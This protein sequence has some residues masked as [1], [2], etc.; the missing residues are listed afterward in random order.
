MFMQ[1][2][3]FK[4]HIER[5]YGSD[6]EYDIEIILPDGTSAESARKYVFETYVRHSM[7]DRD[8]AGLS[9]LENRRVAV[10]TSDEIG[11][12]K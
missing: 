1:K 12:F 5:Y 6:K 11:G 8:S 2:F 9:I 3:K 4:V 10:T 7:D